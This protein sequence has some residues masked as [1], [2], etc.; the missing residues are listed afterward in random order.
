MNIYLLARTDDIGWDEFD[1]FV[2][3][4]TNETKA[5]ELIK[6][7]DYGSYFN[8]RANVDVS[9]IGTTNDS[10]TDEKVVLDSFNAG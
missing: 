1:S 4:A 7:F 9:I 2:V 8:N 6:E 10:I 5:F 3:A